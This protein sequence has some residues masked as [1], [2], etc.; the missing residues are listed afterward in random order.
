MTRL[1][2]AIPAAVVLALGVAT[3]TSQAPRPQ[4][5]A[6]A[7]PAAAASIAQPKVAVPL[8]SHAPVTTGMSTEAQ[9]DM[10]K[11]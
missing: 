4:D 3:A 11:Q 8:V 2:L 1:L 10:V 9:T 5:R 6:T 7:A